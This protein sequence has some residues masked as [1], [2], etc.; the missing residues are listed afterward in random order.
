MHF[1]V[2]VIAAVHLDNQVVVVVAVRFLQIEDNRL[3]LWLRLGGFSLG[4][5]FRFV[6]R[7]S[8]GVGDGVG[9]RL[10]GQNDGDVLRLFRRLLGGLTRADLLP[11]GL[12][13]G[14]RLP[15]DLDL[16]DPV[17]LRPRIEDENPIVSMSNVKNLRTDSGSRNGQRISPNL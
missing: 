8:G 11:V 9:G 14:E 16:L 1:L 7:R 5:N 12:V 6:S 17:L 15:P 13:L 3:R 2:K 10:G 4:S